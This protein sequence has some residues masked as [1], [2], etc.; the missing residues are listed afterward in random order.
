MYQDTQDTQDG[1]EIIQDRLDTQATVVSKACLECQATVDPLD[2]QDIQAIP[3]E[4]GI[5]DVVDI[6]GSR[7]LQGPAVGADGVGPREIQE[8]QDIPGQQ[9]QPEA[10][11]IQEKAAIPVTQ[12]DPDGQAKVV[13][14]VAQEKVVIPDLQVIQDGVATQEKT[15]QRLGCSTLVFQDLITTVQGILAFNAN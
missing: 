6:L 11:A 3:V 2:S 7:V 14:Q 15:H 4:A 8:H 9:A 5:Q 13:I 1:A 10:L 12:D